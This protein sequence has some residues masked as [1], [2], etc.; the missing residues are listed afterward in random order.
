MPQKLFNQSKICEKLQK[1]HGGYERRKRNTGI[2]IAEQ[3]FFKRHFAVYERRE[4]IDLDDLDFFNQYIMGSMQMFTGFY[5]YT[6]FLKKKIKPVYYFLFTVLGITVIQSVRAGKMA[7]FMLYILLLSISGFLICRIWNISVILYAVIIVEIMQFTFGI[8]N[9]ALCILY[10]SAGMFNQEITGI[11][12]MVLGYFSLPVTALCCCIADQF[13]SYDETAKN[14]Y[15]LMLLTPALMIFLTGEYINSAIYGNTI[16]TDSSGMISDTNHY[17]MLIIQILGLGSLFC[18]MF[19]YKKLLENF[20]LHTKL[21]LLEQEEH[22]LNQ[23]VAEAKNRYE[24]TKS[25]RHDIKNHLAV[26]KKLLQEGK[27]EQAV[28]YM[29]DMD[30]ITEQLSFLCNTNN[31]AADILIENKLGMAKNMG[32]D[33]SCSL[34]L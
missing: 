34:S 16:V 14:Q 3:R 22:S 20:H 12:F 32:I 28:S 31:P 29:G 15:T 5:F 13:F 4:D 9:S 23:Y 21:S 19:S 8:F 7:E 2:T 11:L 6:R 17:Q 1:W 10:P 24:K 26:L 18:M 33:V 30:E 27:T 25:F